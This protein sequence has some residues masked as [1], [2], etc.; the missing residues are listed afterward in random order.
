MGWYLVSS[1]T[2]VSQS[3]SEETPAAPYSPVISQ[4]PSHL[5]LLFLRACCA[6][7]PVSGVEGHVGYCLYV[8]EEIK[9]QVG[10]VPSTRLPGWSGAELDLCP[11]QAPQGPVG[12]SPQPLS[13]SQ[14]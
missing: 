10:Q 14:V 3:R 13:R 8:D 2:P 11:A 5:W 12:A 9:A 7:G 6:L 1:G 4:N